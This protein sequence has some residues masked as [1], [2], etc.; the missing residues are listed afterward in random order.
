MCFI[1]EPVFKT[2]VTSHYRRPELVEACHHG[3]FNE[4]NTQSVDCHANN[5]NR[6]YASNCMRNKPWRTIHVNVMQQI[7]P[8]PPSHCVTICMNEQD[9]ERR[10]PNGIDYWNIWK[11]HFLENNKRH[12]ACYQRKWPVA[13]ADKIVFPV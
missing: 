11:S 1:C 12:N 10:G 5:E 9:T 3:R 4:K 13:F 7:A 8:K 6:Q 2:Y